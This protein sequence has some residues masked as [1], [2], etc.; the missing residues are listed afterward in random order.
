[1]SA[2]L[3]VCALP[4]AWKVVR[5]HRVEQVPRRCIEDADIGRLLKLEPEEQ[6][7]DCEI[8]SAWLSK[9][10]GEALS[11]EMSSF[12]GVAQ[13]PAKGSISI[14]RAKAAMAAAA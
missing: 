11:H 12:V 6:A 5:F 4:Q 1:M 7:S 3:F 14:S 13:A 8:R 10:P 2:A 9:V